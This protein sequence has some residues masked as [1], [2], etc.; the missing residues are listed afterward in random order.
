MEFAF[1]VLIYQMFLKFN[2]DVFICFMYILFQLKQLSEWIVQAVR[3][4]KQYTF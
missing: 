4:L 2:C 1:L 3:K